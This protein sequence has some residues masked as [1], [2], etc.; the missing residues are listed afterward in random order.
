[1]QLP[2]WIP[3]TGGILLLSSGLLIAQT[4]D[5][6][7]SA[8]PDIYAHPDCPYFGPQRER[9]VTDA[10][11]KAGVSPDTHKLS[12]TTEGVTAMLSYVP[13]GSRRSEERRVGKEC[14]C[15][16]SAAD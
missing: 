11:R 12:R 3:V 10:L 2:R 8:D 13:G 1:M 5:Q 7:S 6:T 14:R 16:W 9:F 15:G 4:E